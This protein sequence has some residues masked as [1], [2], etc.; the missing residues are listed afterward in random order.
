MRFGNQ[1]PDVYIFRYVTEGTF[2]AYLWQTVE[3]KQK[4][5]SQIMTSKSPV[6]S[7]EDVDETALSYAEIKALCSGN[8]L[9]KEKIDLDIEVSRL[10]LLKSDY[11]SQHHR[12]E[13]DLLETFPKNIQTAQANIAALEHDVARYQANMP[14]EPPAQAEPVATD[15]AE[16]EVKLE[17]AK[18]PFPPMT[19]MGTVYTE[20][21]AAGKALLDACKSV[22][23]IEAVPVGSYLGFDL[24]MNFNSVTKKFKLTVKGEMSY[25]VDMG[26]DPFG[27]ITRINNALK[28]DMPERLQSNRAN[29]ENIHQQVKDA[30]V[31]LAK[32]FEMEQALA[33]KEMRLALVNAE[34]NIEDGPAPMEAAASLGEA[35]SA[36]QRPSILDNLR[37]RQEPDAPKPRQ[38]KTAG[39][40]ILR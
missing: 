36:R 22:K 29:L 17:A 14:K 26:I 12:L 5:I 11:Q 32:P 23:D 20:K 13:D 40:D 3:N 31:E 15:A 21:E 6:R 28:V 35:A 16:G 30:K 19:V 37:A 2:D 24:S 27:N 25:S 9:I 10:R 39:A 34:L 8:P 18:T 4:F 38:D 1:N 33:E 7:C